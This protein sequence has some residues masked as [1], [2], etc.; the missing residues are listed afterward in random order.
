MSTVAFLASVVDPR[1]AAAASKAALDEFAAIR[2][3]KCSNIYDETDMEEIDS[4]P[5]QQI[6][7]D[8]ADKNLVSSDKMEADCKII[9]LAAGA[10]LA[11]AAVKARQLEAIEDKQLSDLTN[12]L[13][14]AQ[15]KKVDI[16][17]K[18][19]EELEDI[20][21]KEFDA[22]EAARAQLLNERQ[23]FQLEQIRAAELKQRALAAQRLL[24]SDSR[25]TTASQRANDNNQQQSSSVQQMPTTVQHT[26]YHDDR[27]QA[28]AAANISAASNAIAAVVVSNSTASRATSSLISSIDA[29]NEEDEDCRMDCSTNDDDSSS[30][31]PVTASLD[32]GASPQSFADN[33]G[34]DNSIDNAH[35]S[36]DS[37]DLEVDDESSTVI[38]DKTDKSRS[39][40]QC[41]LQ[42]N[43]PVIDL[44][45]T[46][47]GGITK[48]A[49][50]NELS[51]EFSGSEYSRRYGCPTCRKKFKH[52]HHLKE[53]SRL[54]TGEKPY[55]CDRC[56]KRFSH[57]GSYSQHMNQKIKC[58][59]SDSD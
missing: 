37:T 20:L 36:K 10:A 31:V 23:Q 11:S 58:S 26:G 12:S 56:G 4:K 15:M 14:Q 28:I 33:N 46:I 57:S 19:F 32:S 2:D 29:A 1:V 18:Q 34:A 52:K 49:V 22:L 25:V 21:D 43:E 51:N 16:K 47:D 8:S 35:N 59:V 17:L 54:H 45:T 7:T 41:N 5:L 13:I 38:T 48:C 40:Q 30:F 39:M 55:A 50:D 44:N 24:M 27:V 9:K 3:D 53:H 42:V 6:K